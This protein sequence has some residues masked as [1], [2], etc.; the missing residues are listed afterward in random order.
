MHQN[1]R[2]ASFGPAS[3]NARIV[4]EGAGV[5]DGIGESIGEPRERVDGPRAVGAVIGLEFGQMPLDGRRASGKC[6][7]IPAGDGDSRE[8]VEFG[9]LGLGPRF[10]SLVTERGDQW[11]RGGEVAIERGLIRVVQGL[12][13]G[14]PFVSTGSRVSRRIWWDSEKVSNHGLVGGATY[15]ALISECVGEST[16]LDGRSAGADRAIRQ[17]GA[18]QR[19]KP[20]GPEESVSHRLMSIWHASHVK[21]SQFGRL[22]TS[23]LAR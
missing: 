15:A 10:D 12:P 20:V 17:N 9:E 18:G 1:E 3:L 14:R 5:K 6:S 19:V 4:D 22:P 11:P 16:L 13:G 8:G 23:V 21:G 2:G 7:R